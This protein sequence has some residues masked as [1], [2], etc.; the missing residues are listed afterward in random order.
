MSTALEAVLGAPSRSVWAY[1]RRP[2][3]VRAAPAHGTPVVGRLAAETD[4][5]TREVVLV[6]D[7][8]YAGCVCGL[9]W[10]RTA[11]PAGSRATPSTSCARRCARSW[12]TRT[13]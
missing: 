2:A 3:I 9:R 12:S 7:G 1:V 13:G 6:L 10:S 4:F 8:P 11:R 5:G